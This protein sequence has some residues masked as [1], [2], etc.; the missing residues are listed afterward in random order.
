MQDTIIEVFADVLDTAEPLDENSDFFDSGGNSV[1]AGRVVARLTQRLA[2]RVT[3][4][5]M[6]HSRTPGALAALISSRPNT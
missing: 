1:L 4:R 3:M 2:V 6:F 5:D